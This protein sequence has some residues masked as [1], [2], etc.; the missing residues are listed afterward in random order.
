MAL[1]VQDDSASVDGANAYV[2]VAEFKAYHDARGNDYSTYSDTDIEEAIVDATDFMD[3]RWYFVGSQYRPGQRTAWPRLNAFDSSDNLRQGVPIEVK[4]ACCE[5][6]F[7]ALSQELDPDPERD[8]T[9]QPVSKKVDKVDVLMEERTYAG[10]AAY[11]RPRYPKGDD[12]LM[13]T[14]LVL[15]PGDLDRG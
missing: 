8:D 13:T 5:Y 14:G 6:A 12:R 11:R 2:T 10:A 9:G 3:G 1:L 7:V 15:S 4:D